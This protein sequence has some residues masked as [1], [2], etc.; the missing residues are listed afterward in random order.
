MIGSQ[1]QLRPKKN[2]LP[3]VW[4]LVM[5]D[6]KERDDFGKKLYGTRLQPHNGRDVLLDIYEEL[7]DAVV[8]IRQAMYERDGK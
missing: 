4:D 6:I 3:A 8:Y 5:I 2:D 1:D 7:L